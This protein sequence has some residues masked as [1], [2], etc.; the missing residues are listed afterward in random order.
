MGS[1]K[2]SLLTLMTLSC[3]VTDTLATIFDNFAKKN[4]FHND[5]IYLII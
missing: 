1:L 4:L 3:I 5:I 2:V